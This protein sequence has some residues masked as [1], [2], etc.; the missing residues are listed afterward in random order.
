MRKVVK[1]IFFLVFVI[2]GIGF[3]R[4]F[5]HVI[6]H[7]RDVWFSG[8]Y[9]YIIIGF[10]AYLPVHFLFHRLIVLHVFGHE[11]TH[12]LWS[13]LFGGKMHEMYVSREE[14][15]YAKYSRGNFLVTLAPYFF[16]LYAIFFMVLH[17]IVAARFKPYID[18]LLGFSMS[19]HVLLTLYSIRRDQPDLRRSGVFFSLAFIYMMNCVALGAILCVVT[20]GGTVAFLRDGIHIFKHI[21][22]DIVFTY[23]WL[24]LHGLRP[25]FDVFSGGYAHL[26]EWLA[27]RY[28]NSQGKSG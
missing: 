18:G 7:P 4:A 20:G 1:G 10:A 8:T 9:L 19:F 2:A 11:L 22:P 13:M 15:G 21:W 27:E 12:V 25:L 23:N 28:A 17:L 5:W 16:P 14:G 24:Y 26:K 6:D 3:S